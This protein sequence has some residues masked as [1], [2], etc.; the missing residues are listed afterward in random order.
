MKKR[1]SISIKISNET[2]T[3]STTYKIPG[4][5]INVSTDGV[6]LGESSNH[7]RLVPADR[8]SIGLDFN[9]D[10]I[11]LTDK[12]IYRYPKLTLP[13]NKVNLLKDK[14][15]LKLVRDPDK[16][17]YHIVSNKFI[18]TMVSFSWNKHYTFADIFSFFKQLKEDG[19][20]SQ[21]GITKAQDIINHADRDGAF[22]FVNTYGYYDDPKG[23]NTYNAYNKAKDQLSKR[24]DKDTFKGYRKAIYIA[25]CDQDKIDDYTKVTTN[26][27]K[28]VWDTDILDIIDEDL[29]VIDNSQYDTIEQMIMSNDRESR[30]LAVEML[31]NC[32]INKSFDVVSGLYY[33]NYD[34]FKDSNYWNSVNVKS[35]RE[36][37]K[38]YEGSSSESNIYSYN[39]YLQK[40]SEQG[41]LTKFAVDRTRDRLAKKVMSSYVNGK[42][43]FTLNKDELV[44]NSELTSQIIDE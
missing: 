29:A 36:Q 19:V 40:L 16:A 24:G 23:R 25:A 9:N 21:S 4:H 8:K 28:L 37:M 1:Y 7:W 38:E 11:D 20:L 22:T 17:D 43:A 5:A 14:F 44:L 42:N 27:H 31:A 33:W 2:L 3:S 32:N 35:L 13:R 6:V 26:T 15:N 10:S 12:K 30:T 34:W 18:N 41:K 39:T